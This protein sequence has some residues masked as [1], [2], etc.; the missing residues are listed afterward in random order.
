MAGHPKNIIFLTC[1][2]FGVLPPV[3]RRTPNQA[4]YQ[5]LSGYTAKIA[6]TELGVTEPQATFSACYGQAFLSLH[7]T[8]YA[9]ILGKK[10]HDHDARAYLLNTGWV[11]GPYGVG[12]RMALKPTRAIIDA[13]LDGSIEDAEFDTLPIFGLQFPKHLHDVP[14]DLLNPRDAWADK[15]AYDESL[16]KLGRMF[17]DNFRRFAD[18]DEGRR[19]EG[20]GPK[21]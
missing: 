17:V 11:A 14:D 1:D 20:V 15:A 18:N 21:L 3:S 10:M 6:G 7:P 16:Q 8:R 12:H 2:A 5:Y 19:I 9:E 13:I 4:M